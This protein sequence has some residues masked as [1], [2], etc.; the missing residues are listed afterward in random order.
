MILLPIRRDAQRLGDLRIIRIRR[1]G[2]RRQLLRLLRFTRLKRVNHRQALLRQ[3][4]FR[5]LPQRRLVVL[6]RRTQ[7]GFLLTG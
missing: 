7:I 4:K 2:F 1:P 6:L 5:I 3:R